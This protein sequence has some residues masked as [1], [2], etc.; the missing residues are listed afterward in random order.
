ME[1]LY[2]KSFC[3]VYSSLKLLWFLNFSEPIGQACYVNSCILD[4]DVLH[5]Q[6]D[7]GG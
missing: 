4:L 6:T 2:R 7:K 3:C 5:T 1:F